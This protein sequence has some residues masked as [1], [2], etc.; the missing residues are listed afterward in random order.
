MKAATTGT[1]AGSSSFISRWSLD[2]TQYGL[3]HPCNLEIRIPIEKLA[4]EH[5]SHAYLK[6][7][8]YSLCWS[9][10]L[11]FLLFTCTFDMTIGA[12]VTSK[13]GFVLKNWAISGYTNFGPP[14]PPHH[15]CKYSLRGY[16]WSDKKVIWYEL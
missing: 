8:N 12:F 15:F 4:Y 10:W 2:S 7:I 1:R 9:L 13:F 5:V 14:P 6:T 3:F 16:Y 11:P